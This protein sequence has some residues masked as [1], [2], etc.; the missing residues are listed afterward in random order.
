MGG[1]TT[2]RFDLIV[3]GLGAMGAATLFHAR[4][5]GLRVLG[6]D[7]Y[8]PPHEFGSSHAETRITRLA[9]GEGPEYLP[10]VARSHEIW[11]ALEAET[12]QDLLHQSGCCIITTQ[13]VPD[14]DRWSDFVTATATVAEAGSVDFQLLDPPELRRQQPTILIADNDR[15]GLEPTGG[16]VL[17]ERAVQIQL[18]LAKADG[19]ELRI[20]EK[21]VSADVD[22]G[23]TG[24]TV[25]TNRSSYTADKVVMA[26]GAW[27][28]EMVEPADKAQMTVTRQVVFWFEVEDL[29]AYSVDRFPAVIWVG[30]TIDDYLGAFP[31]P[32]S[33]T[34]GL[35]VL[36]EQF[37]TTTDAESVNRHVSQDEIDAFH[38]T[39]V[40]PRLTGVTSNCLKAAVCLYTN[41]KDDHFLIDSDPRSSRIITM[42][43]CSGH[44]FKHSTALGEA[45][46]EWAAT[47][48]STLDLTPFRRRW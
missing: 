42:S 24:V 32:T 18:Q 31:I 29:S 48:R 11:R 27:L 14:E 47:G 9:V 37:A 34:R 19:A 20:N 13:D 4:R 12:G 6:I 45:V 38:R 7:R 39:L 43:P 26:T 23:N 16:I 30:E 36:G 8:R 41:T 17:S 33:G 15:A 22:G 10:F 2:E 40:A 21:V 5:Q 44:G 46:A 25:S 28:P 1:K 35:K 3:V